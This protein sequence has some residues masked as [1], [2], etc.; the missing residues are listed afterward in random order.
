MQM[1][2]TWVATNTNSKNIVA[3]AE[4]M[5]IKILTV[6]IENQIRKVPFEFWGPCW[7]CWKK[8]HKAAKYHGKK[9]LNDDD[10]DD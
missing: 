1:I 8:G 4:S 10:K 9:D 3:T 2:R 5:G 6:P 7:V